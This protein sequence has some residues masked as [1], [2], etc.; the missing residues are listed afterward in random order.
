MEAQQGSGI[1]H[2]V[3]VHWNLL[4]HHV[5]KIPEHAAKSP[6]MTEANMIMK[7]KNRLTHL[8]ASSVADQS[9]YMCRQ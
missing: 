8:L 2:A 7:E 1:R 6:V 3:D 4:V 9:W 5:M